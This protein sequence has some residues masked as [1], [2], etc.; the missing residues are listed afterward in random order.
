MMFPISYV[1]AFGFKG[2]EY[3]IEGDDLSTLEMLDGTPLITLDE[4]IAAD[5]VLQKTQYVLDRKRE[6]NKRGCTTE[7]LIIALWEERFENRPESALV[8]QSIREQIKTEF[9]KPGV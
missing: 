7:E 2:R 3:K 1:L 9:P 5:A 4:I 6:Y 8:L